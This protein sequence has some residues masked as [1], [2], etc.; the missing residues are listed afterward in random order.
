MRPAILSLASGLRLHYAE[1]G[2]TGGDAIVFLHGWPDS[3]F[4]FSRVAEGLPDESRA[5]LLDQRGFGDSERPDHGYE[6]RDFAADV[7]AFLDAVSVERATVVG[8][9]FGSFVARQVAIAY[10]E[11]VDR[12]VLVGTGWSGSN[13]VTREV[14]ASLSDLTDPVPREFAREFQAST[15]YAPLPE[16]FFDRIIAESL[17]LPA[18][19]WREILGAVIRYDDTKDLN[20]M[21]TPTVLLWGDR[22]ALFSR[23]DQD[24]LVAAI[25]NARLRIYPEIGHCPNWECPSLVAADLRAFMAE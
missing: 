16:P 7:A 21:K 14:Y 18:R 24:Q 3:W 17:K 9:S 2:A 1:H 11:R 22:D 25:P 6:I 8:H 10:P 12:L 5:F 13:A 23:A 4:S 20:E 19:L 15:A